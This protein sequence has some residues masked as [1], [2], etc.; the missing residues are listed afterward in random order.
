MSEEDR[1]QPPKEEL[2]S[3]LEDMGKKIEELPMHAM[4]SPITHADLA[5]LIML[6]VSIFKKSSFPEN[7]SKI[8]EKTTD[9]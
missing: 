5:A 2:I 4:F 7:F 1:L 9:S 8:V 6:L 3:I